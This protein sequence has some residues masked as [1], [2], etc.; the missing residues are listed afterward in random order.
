MKLLQAGP[1]ERTSERL[2]GNCGLAAQPL[3]G[4][5]LKGTRGETVWHEERTMCD[6]A[7]FLQALAS[8]VCESI[9]RDRGAVKKW[10]NSDRRRLIARGEPALCLVDIRQIMDDGTEGGE[11]IS[12]RYG[13]R[14]CD[15][16]SGA[17]G[18]EIDW[19]NGMQ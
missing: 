6:F 17:M 12:G 19:E 1:I 11:H 7:R 2:Y 10:G 14:D 3:P 9:N 18:S 16:M 15:R 4:Q 8:S 5:E 13:G